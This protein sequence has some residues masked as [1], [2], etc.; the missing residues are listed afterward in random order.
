M[1]RDATTIPRLLLT[2]REAAVALR[3]SERTLW[4][5]TAPRGTIPAVRINRSVRYAV[6]DLRRWIDAQKEGGAEQ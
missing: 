5:L 3:V 6:D 1:Q 4:S 2:A